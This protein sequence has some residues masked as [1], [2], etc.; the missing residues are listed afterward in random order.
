MIVHK[1]KFLTGVVLMAVF[2]VVLVIIFMPVFGGMNGLDYLDN[3]YNFALAPN[4]NYARELMERLEPLGVSWSCQSSLDVGLET[5]MLEL[6][7][8]SGCSMVLFGFESGVEVH[9]VAL[10]AEERLVLLQQVV[11]HGSVGLVS[12]IATLEHGLVLEQMVEPAPLT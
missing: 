8:R 4:Q 3:L 11:R 5:D 2:I 1:G 9:L 12:G 6:M 10:Q 7:A